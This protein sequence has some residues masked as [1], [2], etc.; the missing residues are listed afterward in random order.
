MPDLIATK[1]HEMHS[2]FEIKIL[3]RE[4]NAHGDLFGRLMSDLFLSL[5]YDAVRLNVARSGREIDIVAKHRLEPR[6]AIAECKA[7]GEKVGGAE[8][9]KLAGKLRPERQ[10]REDQSDVTGYFI[11]LSGFTESAID[12]E[13]ESRSDAVILIDANR[14]VQELIKGR[15]LVPIEVADERAGRL[16]GQSRDLTLDKAHE[17]LAY[18]NCWVW[19][20][21][22]SR[23]HERT[24]VAFI[25]ADGTPIASSIAREVVADYLRID[26]GIA[27]LDCLNR[28]I[29]TMS[30]EVAKLERAQARYHDYL[31]A[32][33][34]SILLDGLPADAVVGALRL[35]LEDLFVP[36]N[37]ITDGGL[38]SGSGK[39][40]QQ[41]VFTHPK[42]RPFG[43]TLGR[44]NRL[45]VLAS[46]GGG[47]S[48][49]IKRLAVAYSDPARRSLVM[50]Q[51]PE[52]S[53]T[54]VFLRC[55][56]LRDKSRMSFIELLDEMA[57]RAAM[58]E[59]K[60]AFIKTL[61]ASLRLGAVLLLVDGLDEI[62]DVGDRTAFVRNLRTFLA[63]YPNVSLV[64]ASPSAR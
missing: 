38:L 46:P 4:G 44:F 55:R 60:S 37:V 14:A 57:N 54:P 3:A 21:Y 35:K 17:L 13:C 61:H 12:Q 34:G 23:D 48:T 40:W 39:G 10:R 20:V 62:T 41:H 22:F 49:L 59:D 27:S 52:R 5:G 47:K 6:S 2:T 36:M 31:V 43:A 7:T 8:I 42:P 58:G 24:H 26:S 63:V 18:K 9:N 64:L 30:D 1:E 50:D 25:H 32:E 33:C 16:V 56:E 29:E 15:I 45:A 19:A 28:D 51:L 11:S 53:W